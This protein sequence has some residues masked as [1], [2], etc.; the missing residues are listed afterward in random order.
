MG[1][2]L[3]PQGLSLF[4]GGA[5]AGPHSE[6][7]LGRQVSCLVATLQPALYVA[8]DTLNV[9]ATSFLGIPR[10]TAASSR[11]LKSDE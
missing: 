5:N 2:E 3:L 4:E 9:F 8:S 1:F 7:R 6:L 11:S 10:S